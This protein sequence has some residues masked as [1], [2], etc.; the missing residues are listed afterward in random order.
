MT[1]GD[2]VSDIDLDELVTFHKDQ[3]RLA[4]VTAARPPAWRFGKLTVLEGQVMK[5]AE[6]PQMDEGWINGGFFVLEP[7]VFDFIPGDVDFAVEPLEALT[8]AGELSAY[9][10]EGFWQCMDTLRDRDLLNALWDG[11]HPPW[12]VWNT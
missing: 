7:R 10:H 1:Y 2:G 6:K 12:R 5:F 9:G 4:T 8:A 11:G 3:G